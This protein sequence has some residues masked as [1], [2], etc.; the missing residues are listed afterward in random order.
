MLRGLQS[1]AILITEIAPPSTQAIRAKNASGESGGGAKLAPI[2]VAQQ[3]GSSSLYWSHNLVQTTHLGAITSISCHESGM[4]ALASEDQTI[5]VVHL[6]SL[7]AAFT[8]QTNLSAQISASM[9]STAT[10]ETYVVPTSRLHEHTQGIVSIKISSDG[11]IFSIS[12]DHTLK[13]SDSHSQTRLASFSFPS[14]LTCFALS[15]AEDIVYVGANDGNIYKINLWDITSRTSRASNSS[16]AASSNA[17]Q[18]IAG[19]SASFGAN[20]DWSSSISSSLAEWATA[21]EES[22]ESAMDTSNQASS[23]SSTSKLGAGK[24]LQGDIE[25]NAYRGHTQ[26]ISSVSLSLDGSRLVSSAMDGSVVIWDEKTCQAIHRVCPIKGIGVAWSHLFV[27]PLSAASN[28]PTKFRVDSTTREKSSIP[29][30]LPPKPQTAIGAPYGAITVPLGEFSGA[31]PTAL[32]SSAS[33]AYSFLNMDT[34]Q[35]MRDLS[36]QYQAQDEIFE[37]GLD[38]AERL[39]ASH[40]DELENLKQE[41]AKEKAMNAKWKEVNNSL[42]SSS[43]SSALK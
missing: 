4:I 30:A 22:V 43:L 2:E 6:A 12:K 16:N 3:G 33:S 18:A 11:R 10:P 1:G 29:F 42:F 37:I 13:I 34:Q 23:L 32:N 40:A 20:F 8:P 25:P 7:L 19:S 9:R 27:R 41:L 17:S 15:P 38:L 24:T 39:Q 5:S 35:M 26:P 21:E 31:L 14:A 36:D 28:A